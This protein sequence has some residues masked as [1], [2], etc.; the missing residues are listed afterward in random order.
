MIMNK[1]IAIAPMLSFTTRHFRYLIRLMSR[2]TWLY[3]EMVV[4]SSLLH[5][6]LNRFLKFNADEHP[7]AL[8]LGGSDPTELKQC[9]KM[10][11]DFGYDEVNL[12]L[13]CPSKRVQSGSFGACLMHEPQLV[14]E[15]VNQ[16]V[17]NI[18]L[19]VSVKM[20][21]GID[22]QHSYSQL[23]DF[24]SLLVQAGCKKFFVHARQAYLNLNT[25]D[26]LRLPALQYD[27]VYQLKKDF[28]QLNII[29]NGEIKDYAA[30]AEHFKFTDGVMIGREAVRNPYFFA[31]ID[32]LFFDDQ[33]PIKT[34]EEI[35][36]QYLE[37][38]Q[39]ELSEGSNLNLLIRPILNLFKGTPQGK[40]RI[41]N[42]KLRIMSNVGNRHACSVVEP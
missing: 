20:R 33:L 41:T 22:D 17:N 14:A 18:K 38:V 11:E 6:D 4:T 9:A 2:Y 35:G 5:G 31:A 29:I 3:T 19:P 10:A 8:Q 28:P 23:C 24:I 26:N 21:L 39:Q 13:G 25:K 1:I 15:C 34:R 7:I 36:E 30:M 12:N 16:M 27:V 37:Y 32:N 42:Y 40:L